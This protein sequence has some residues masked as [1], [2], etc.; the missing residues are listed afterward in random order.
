MASFADVRF[1]AGMGLLFFKTYVVGVS[2]SMKNR[3][4]KK[5]KYL[6]EPLT[7]TLVCSPSFFYHTPF[8]DG[9]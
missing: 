2:G 3:L 8:K 7:C 4:T 1:T 9:Y 6:E 5:F